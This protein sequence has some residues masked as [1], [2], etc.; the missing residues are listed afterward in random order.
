MTQ[1]AEPPRSPIL[2]LWASR[3]RAGRVHSVTRQP[4]GEWR[5]NCEA[6]MNGTPCWAVKQ[7][8]TAFPDADTEGEDTG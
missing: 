4:D 2:L 1:K 3:T 6:G 5:C 7:T 8:Q